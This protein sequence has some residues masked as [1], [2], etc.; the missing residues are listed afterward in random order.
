MSEIFFENEEIYATKMRKELINEI[1]ELFLADKWEDPEKIYQMFDKDKKLNHDKLIEWVSGRVQMFEDM[2]MAEK[3]H[4]YLIMRKSDDKVIGLTT[5][6]PMSDMQTL[7][8]ELKMIPGDSIVI[9][10]RIH[11]EERRKGLG[12]MIVNLYFDYIFQTFKADNNIFMLIDKRN[13]QSI[14]LVKKINCIEFRS[15]KFYDGRQ[16]ALYSMITI[17]KL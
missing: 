12:S 4:N 17:Y 3:N 14:R 2:N 10:Y 5:I 8:T 15:M 1:S 7:A 6:Y 11:P 9:A 16:V 13:E